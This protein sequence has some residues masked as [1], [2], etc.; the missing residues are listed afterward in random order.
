[1]KN[2]AEIL[3]IWALMS[4]LVGV[5]LFPVIISSKSFVFWESYFGGSKGTPPIKIPSEMEVAL[6]P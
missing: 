4:F 1:M 2:S 3:L 5:E 6:L